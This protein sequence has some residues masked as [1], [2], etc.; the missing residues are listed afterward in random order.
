MKRVLLGVALCACSSPSEPSGIYSTYFLSAIDGQVLPAPAMDLPEGL[1]VESGWLFFGQLGRPRAGRGGVLTDTVTY[2]R[3]VRGPNG[4]VDSAT[5]DLVYSITR[6][7]V[8]IDLCPPG[9]LCLV[10]TEL[11]GPVDRTTLVLTH[12]LAGTA[13]ST[14]R[15]HAALPD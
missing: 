11:V 10:P 15:F 3:T 7:T 13:R 8:R 9:A 2:S 1:V 14:Y 5:I 12:M 4:Q 6:D